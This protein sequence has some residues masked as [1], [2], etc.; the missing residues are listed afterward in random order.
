[1]ATVSRK[2][3]RGDLKI[4]NPKYQG[5]AY[6]QFTGQTGLSQGPRL[7]QTGLVRQETLNEWMRRE[8]RRVASGKK[9]K[10]L[11]P[12]SPKGYI[13]CLALRAFT[14]LTPGYPWSQQATCVQCNRGIKDTDDVSII[15]ITAAPWNNEKDVTKT[16]FASGFFCTACDIP[17]DEALTVWQQ[18]LRKDGVPIA[19]P[20]WGNT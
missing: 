20:Q 10:K 6:Q 12:K 17:N 7:V 9:P 1:M 4:Q 18:C 14:F 13:E 19:S 15:A 11:H 16:A 8:G 5:E 3:M 2:L